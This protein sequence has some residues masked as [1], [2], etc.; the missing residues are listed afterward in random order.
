[1]AHRLR[2]RAAGAQTRPSSRPRWFM[3]ARMRRND[4]TR[5]G[6]SAPS[7]TATSSAHSGSVAA[8]RQPRGQ[9]RAASCRSGKALIRSSTSTCA[10]PNDR[11]PG[12]VDDPPAERQLEADGGRRRVP[13]APGD[14]VDVADGAVGVGHQGVDQRRL[15]DAAVPHQH[16]RAV[17]QQRRGRPRGRRPGGSRR[18]ARRAG[19]SIATSSSG[20]PRSDLV[21]HTSGSMPASNAATRHRSISPARGGGSASAATITSWSALATMMRSMG[22]SSSAVRRRTVRRGVHLDDAG[23]RCPRRR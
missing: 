8:C 13:A 20:E 11:M 6:A 10:R 16:A 18:P 22:S 12:G 23:Q 3:L 1:M 9:S 7:A 4:S 17:A 5:S 21:R 2:L 19:S 14:G 15:A